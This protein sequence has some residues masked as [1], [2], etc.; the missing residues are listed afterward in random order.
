MKVSVDRDDDNDLLIS[1]ICVQCCRRHVVG[2]Y[3][4]CKRAL[5]CLLTAALKTTK[6]V[7]QL[8]QTDRTKLDTF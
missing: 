2:I 6:Q 5:P 4:D 7:V 3:C 1:T 8:W